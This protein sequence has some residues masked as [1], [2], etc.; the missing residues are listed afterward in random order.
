M[1]QSIL[2]L[3]LNYYRSPSQ[4]PELVDVDAPL[5]QGIDYLLD[6]VAGKVGLNS[7]ELQGSLKGVPVEDLKAAAVSY[8]EHVFFNSNANF[9]RTLGLNSNATQDQIRAHY[10]ALIHILCL[11]QDDKAAQW[12][13]AYAMR[14]NRAYSVLRIPDKREKYNKQ[15][16]IVV[17]EFSGVEK[18]SEPRK[19]L[20]GDSSGSD[21]EGLGSKSEKGGVNSSFIATNIDRAYL[22]KDHE[23]AEDGKESVDKVTETVAV[24][25]DIDSASP[26]NLY[27]PNDEVNEHSERSEGAGDH[28]V[29][30]SKGGAD[31]E[32]A[33]VSNIDKPP[34]RKG[35]YSLLG[36]LL[37]VAIGIAVI[38]FSES[39]QPA[40]NTSDEYKTTA[41]EPEETPQ[42]TPQEPSA[43]IVEKVE[44]MP[45]E[46]IV[47]DLAKEENI[48]PDETENRSDVNVV[49][50]EAVVTD[51][52]EVDDLKDVM[53]DLSEVDDLTDVIT[54]NIEASSDEEGLTG[55]GE[56]IQTEPEQEAPDYGVAEFFETDDITGLS[57]TADE[58]LDDSMPEEEDMLFDDDD[59]TDL[60]KET[61]DGEISV[62]ELNAEKLSAVVRDFVRYYDAGNLDKFIQLFAEDA[63][64]DDRENRSGIREDYADA[65]NLTVK[66]KFLIDDVRWVMLDESNGLGTADF[67][68]FIQALGEDRFAEYTG[69][70]TFYI[71]DRDGAL[72]ITGLYHQYNE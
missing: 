54:E 62:E 23:P 69:E 68:L 44:I 38:Y 33:G 72:L 63:K 61:G 16:N 11:D 32:K 39:F 10:S 6:L 35:L 55:N 58:L 60:D 51:L 64:T 24:A 27:E 13:E 40:L 70:I 31:H 15:N 59:L 46:N 14:I 17:S 56:E 29:A 41:L 19:V 28:S 20:D 34:S 3:V 71:E 43:E 9:Y 67:V 2:E 48:E 65:F 53:T 30:E 42:E 25:K 26:E 66:R 47:G 21:T 18:R 12:D 57:D 37:L 22:S 5:P 49:E 8:I 45:D 36:V 52:S 1:E 50:A 4:Y 7:D